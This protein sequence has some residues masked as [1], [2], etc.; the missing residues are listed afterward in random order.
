LFRV[1]ELANCKK[2]SLQGDYVE[3]RQNNKDGALIGR[4]CGNS[5]LPPVV[6]SKGRSLFV[7]FVTDA[8]FV[9][10]GF[11]AVY[12]AAKWSSKLR[13]NFLSQN[14]LVAW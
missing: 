2:S 5:S 8:V 14:N 11:Q 4:H 10:R 7:R 13:T 9:S 6:L 3:I 12:E 1:F